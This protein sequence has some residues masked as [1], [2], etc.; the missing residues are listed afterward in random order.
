MDLLERFFCVFLFLFGLLM[1]TLC[2]YLKLTAFKKNPKGQRYN[3][4]SWIFAWTRNPNF[5]GEFMLWLGLSI[6]ADAEFNAEVAPRVLIFTTPLFCL[7]VMLV[8]TLG[9]CV[10]KTTPQSLEETK[11]TSGTVPTPPCFGQFLALSIR[12]CQAL[13]AKLS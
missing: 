12:C 8:E 3:L 4:N 7:Y 13:F 9:I 5:A 11:I 6:F 10:R 2:D 1:E